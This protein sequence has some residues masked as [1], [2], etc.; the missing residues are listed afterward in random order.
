M[1]RSRA[2]DSAQALQGDGEKVIV[3]LEVEKR[4]KKKGT[5]RC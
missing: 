2:E 3:D 5:S 4:I 1:T